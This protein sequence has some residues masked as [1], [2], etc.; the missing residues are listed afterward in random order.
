MR[1][2]LSILLL[3][4]LGLGPAAD[5]GALASG[6]ASGW[7]GKIDETRIPACCRRNGKHHCAMSTVGE[8]AQTTGE[9]SISANDCCPCSP[10]ALVSTAPSVVAVLGGRRDAIGRTANLRLPHAS[11]APTRVSDRRSW[12][13]RGPPADQNL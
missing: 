13:K 1:R 11:T 8:T 9:T 10:R 12:P 4:V 3:M 2:I 7:T 5:A 6:P